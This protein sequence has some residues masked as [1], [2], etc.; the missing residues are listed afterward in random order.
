MSLAAFS[1]ALLL[2]VGG[3]RPPDYTQRSLCDLWAGA[4]CQA[5]SC[6]QDS[7]ER[8]QL[9]SRKCRQ[10]SRQVVSRDRADR[11]VACAKALLKGPCGGPPPSE[12]SEVS[13]PF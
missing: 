12:C 8:C 6:M 13:S 4:H 10:A 1:T 5:T 2:L 3:A 11:A 9:A 7:K